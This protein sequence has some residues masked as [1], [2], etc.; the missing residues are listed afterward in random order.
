MSSSPT[1]AYE[2][3]D[4]I[5]WIRLNRP[6]SLNAINPEMLDALNEAIDR[7]R[8]DPELK[9]AVISGEGERAFSAG[10]DLRAY[11]AR[12]AAGEASQETLNIIRFADPDYCPKP[13]VAA[14]RGWCIGM[15][16]HLALSCDFRVCADDAVFQLPETELGMA[17][18]RLSWQ[19][20]RILGLPAALELGV[21]AERKGA[22][23]ALARGL[24]HHVAP[25]GEEL[26]QAEKIA[27][28]LCEL[29]LPAVCATRATMHK[30]FDLSYTEHFE[31]SMALRNAVLD[32]GQDRASADAFAAGHRSHDRT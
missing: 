17:L 32:Q 27:R 30:A 15:G 29:S 5:A 28:R 1:V 19:C 7:Y 10:V 23:W 24:V 20:V 3:R 14:I 9:A 12:T 6:R 13:V 22:Q 8:A 26:A 16:L 25:A 18:T 11:S 21:L 31:Y 4:R 2:A